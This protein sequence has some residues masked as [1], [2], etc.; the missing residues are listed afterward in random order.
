MPVSE[1]DLQAL[2]ALLPALRRIV[3]NDE[4]LE[5]AAGLSETLTTTKAQTITAAKTFKGAAIKV[6]DATTGKL[7]HSFGAKS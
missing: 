6:T 7:I 4:T 1:S 2:V 3:A 5:R